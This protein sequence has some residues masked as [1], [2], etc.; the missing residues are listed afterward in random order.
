MLF[1][2]ILTGYMPLM[3]TQAIYLFLCMISHWFSEV[4]TFQVILS[5]LANVNKSLFVPKDNQTLQEVPVLVFIHY[6][7][8]SKNRSTSEIEVLKQVKGRKVNQ[9]GTHI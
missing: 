9:L 8:S 5:F 3:I 6:S 4:F 7:C 2:Y 1:P